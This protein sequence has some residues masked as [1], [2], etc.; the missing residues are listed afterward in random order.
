TAGVE[1]LDQTAQQRKPLLFRNRERKIVLAARLRHHH[2]HDVSERTGHART[3]TRVLIEDGGEQRAARARQPGDEM[4]FA[5]RHCG[6]CGWH[7]CSLPSIWNV[8]SAAVA[9][10][11]GT[12]LL[13]WRGS[14]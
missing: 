8:G 13:L 2:A 11:H 10:R 7:A 9:R 1:V 14:R 3:E 5:R 4:K 12:Q 6:W